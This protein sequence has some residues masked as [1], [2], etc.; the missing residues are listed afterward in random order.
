MA[1][2]VNLGYKE[3]ITAFCRWIPV[4]NGMA[5]L[6]LKEKTNYDCIFWKLPGDTNTAGGCSVYNERPLQCRDFPFWSSTLVSEE[7][8][9]Q[10][11]G[12]CPGMGKGSFYNYNSIKK[13]LETREKEPIISRKIHCTGDFGLKSGSEL[14]TGSPC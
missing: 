8:W 4:E 10:T 9:K 2:A 5:Q 7:S 1:E 11:A 13:I 12:E 6:S 14:F 3:F